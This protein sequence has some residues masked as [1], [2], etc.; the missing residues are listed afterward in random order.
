MQPEK[1]LIRA[2]NWVGDAVLAIPAMKVVRERFPHSE[3]TLLVRPWVAGLFTSARF[4]DRVWR[5]EKPSSLAEW[6]RIVREI[7]SRAFDLALLLPNSFE[8]ALMMF[9]GGVPHRVGFATDAR[10]W[11]L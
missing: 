1:I 6:T 8:S 3:I 2:P 4:V 10:G 9:L 11:M 5:E 7:R